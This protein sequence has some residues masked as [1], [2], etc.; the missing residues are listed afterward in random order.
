[1]HYPLTLRVPRSHGRS[2]VTLHD[3]QHLDLPAMFPRAERAFRR[4]AWHPS[5]RAADRVIVIS[6]FVRGRAEALLGLDASRLRVVPLGLD[7][8][9]LAPGDAREP[10]LL[11]PARRW[12]HK[13]H[14]RLFEAFALARRERPELRLVLTGAGDFRDAPDGVEARGHVPWPEVVALMRRASALVFPSLYEGFGLPLLEAMACG[15]PVVASRASCL[16]DVAEGAALLVDPNN[17]EALADAL[18]Q[19]LV[20]GALRTRLVADG[21]R[22]AAQYSW[23]RAAERLLG[24]YQKVAAA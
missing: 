22:R 24:V 4:V 14:A 5:I 1:V 16:P 12:P 3:L 23:R 6:E 15:T 18:E 10:F 2:V 21:R 11:Y 19:V 13:N 20:D 8:A 17:V 9:Q 7:H